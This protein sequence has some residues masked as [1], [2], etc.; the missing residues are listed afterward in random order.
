MSCV[1]LLI[2]EQVRSALARGGDYVGRRIPFLA[3]PLFVEPLSLISAGMQQDISVVRC[4]YL[5]KHRYINTISTSRL[6][7]EYRQ[8]LILLVATCAAK[9]PKSNVLQASHTDTI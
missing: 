7:T 6:E 4:S 9:E 5:D 8:Q 2:S 1:A 3:V